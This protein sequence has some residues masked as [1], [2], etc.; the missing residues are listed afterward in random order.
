MSTP[1]SAPPSGRGHIAGKIRAQILAGHYRPGAQ[2]PTFD[3]LVDEF[4]ISRATMQL[5]IRQLKD[6]GFVRSVHRSGLFVSETPPHLHRFGLVFSHSPGAK[7]WNRFMAALLAESPVVLRQ[8]EGMQIVPFQDIHVETT[9][10]SMTRLKEDIITHRLAGVILTEETWFLAESAELLQSKLPCVAL[11]RHE[12]LARGMPVVNTNE[13]M[14]FDKALAWLAQR[15]RKRVAVLAMR[16]FVGLTTDDCQKA[17]LK[18]R[19]HWICPIGSQFSG[20][21]RSVVQLLLDYPP[22]QR[23]D[24]IILATDHLVEEALATIHEA[25]VVIG[26]DIDV[27]AHCNW[28]WPVESPLPIA[29]LGFHSHDFIT[30]ALDVISKIRR[31]ESPPLRTLIPALF[32]HELDSR[33][34]PSRAS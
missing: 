2:L 24:C 6:E 12:T 26:R 1:L 25:G 23:P 3:D 34:I 15:G 10:E 20:Q 9:A 11:N 8:R 16:Q 27:V 5:A 31:G 17:G 4:G 22:E 21:T 30:V 32:E 28:P 7:E 18:T 13:T 19:P 14:F 33:R 29:R